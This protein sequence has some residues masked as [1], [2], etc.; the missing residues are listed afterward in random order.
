[1]TV[2]V[3]PFDKCVPKDK[4]VDLVL[5]DREFSCYHAT[6]S[7]CSLLLKRPDWGGVILSMMKRN[8]RVYL[9]NGEWHRVRYD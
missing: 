3:H 7:D 2:K 8:N 1:M 5:L 9:F 4:D 6:L